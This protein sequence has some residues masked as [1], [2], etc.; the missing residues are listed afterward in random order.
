MPVETVGRGGVAGR[1]RRVRGGGGGIGEAV[2]GKASVGTAGQW[3]HGDAS[4]GG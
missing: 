3:H 2:A 1:H 4:R